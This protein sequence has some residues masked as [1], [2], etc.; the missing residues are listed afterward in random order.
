VSKLFNMIMITFRALIVYHTFKRENGENSIWINYPNVWLSILIS[1][2]STTNTL[3]WCRI[4]S[5]MIGN[6]STSKDS[7]IRW[8][9][10][11]LLD[12]LLIGKGIT[13]NLKLKVQMAEYL[14][15]F[16]MFSDNTFL[17]ETKNQL[18]I[19]FKPAIAEVIYFGS[20][21]LLYFRNV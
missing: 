4:H 12:N 8:I 5:N 11:S 2:N 20:L 16:D 3:Y 13:S 14:A 18:I 1:T 19:D 9:E 17:L 15:F 21:I 7:T 6:V 10:I